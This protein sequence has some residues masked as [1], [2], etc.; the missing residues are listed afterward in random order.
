MQ[1]DWIAKELAELDLKDKR[2]HTRAKIIVKNLSGSPEKSIPSA[3]N[4]WHETKA[5]YRFMS[6]EKVTFEKILGVHSAAT[7][8]RIEEYQTIILAQDTS[9]LDY[10]GQDRK[11]GRGPTN[12][13][14]HKGVFLHPLVAFT[15]SGMCL[16]VLDAQVWYREDIGNREDDLKKPIEEKESFRWLKELRKANDLGKL[17][18]NKTFIMVADREADIYEVLSEKLN[19]NVHYV[20]RAHHNRSL[21]ESEQK[22]VEEIKHQAALGKIEFDYKERDTSKYRSVEQEIKVKKLKLEPSPNRGKRVNLQ[23]VEVTAMLTREIKPKEGTEPIEWLLL[24]GLPLLNLEDALKA[25][26]YYLLRWGIEIYFKV[27]K[28]G[29]K[30][31]ELQLDGLDRLSKCLAFYMIIAWRILYLIHLGRACPEMSCEVFF[32]EEEWRAAYMVHYRK[33]PPREAPKLNEMILVVGGIG[34]FLGRKSDGFPGPKHL[35]I[36]I[37]RIRDFAYALEIQ[38]EV[39]G[40]NICG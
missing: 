17:Y 3:H 24:T 10:E 7:L 35:W 30:I 34:G 20:I 6:N 28:S 25:I 31:E 29:C 12:H 2:L 14:S 37:Q 39:W 8:K 15:D 27:L 16:G 22:L 21:C 1:M 9:D 5:A 23:P 32:D 19:P 4:G 11:K 33:K 26:H 36:G 38:N 13:N 18:P 40:A